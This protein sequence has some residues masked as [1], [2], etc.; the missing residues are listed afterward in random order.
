MRRLDRRIDPLRRPNA[1]VAPDRV[2]QRIESAGDVMSV[3]A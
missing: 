3:L 2:G 1:V